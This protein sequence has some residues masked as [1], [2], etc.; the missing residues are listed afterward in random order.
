MNRK[1]RYWLLTLFLTITASVFAQQRNIIAVPDTKVSIGEAQLPVTIE[2]TDEIVGLQFD[3]TL[4][5]AVTAGSDAISTNRCDGHTIVIRKMEATRYRVMLYS[6]EM[7]PLIAQQGTV[8]YIPITTPQSYSQ[9]GEHPMSISNAT[10]TIASGE[11]VLTDAKA[12]KLIVTDL[13]DLTVKSIQPSGLTIV[14]NER[15]SLSWQVQN[16]GGASTGKGWSEQILLVNRLGTRTKLLATTYCEE[17]LTA[18]AVLTRQAEITV[19]KLLGIEGNAYLQVRIVPTSETGE[20]T[21]AQGNNTL[22]ATETF[23]VGK[24][25][26]VEISPSEISENSSQRIMVKVSRSGDWSGEQ[27]FSLSSSD[28]R[29]RLPQQVTIPASQSGAEVFT[30]I[31]DNTAIDSN[32]SVTISASGNG[33]DTATGQL[34]IIDNEFAN[35]TLTASKSTITEGETF[36]LTI[37]SSIT[38]KNNPLEV[39]LSCENAKRFSFPQ[40]VS[41]PV[42]KKTAKVEVTAID[43]DVPSQTLSTAFTASAPQYNKAEAIVLLQDNDLPVLTLELTPA[44]V[45]E[46]DG[47]LAVAAVLRRTTHTDAKITVRISD[48][49]NGA[50]YYGNQTLELAKGVEEVHFNLGPVDNSNVDGDRTY[51]ITAAVWLSS[52][53]CSAGGEAAG[54]VSAQLRVLDDDGPALSITSSKSTVKEGEKTTLT[55]ERNTSN[56][57]QALTV[58]LS[59]DYEDGLTYN[60]TVTIAAKKK[61]ATVEVTAK[62]NSQ[63]NDNH[64]VVFTAQANGFATGTCYIMVTDQTLPDARIS[65]F[66][67]NIQETEVGTEA[68]LTIV[69]N[70]E[71]AAELPA[72]VAVKVYRQGESKAVATLYT[73]EA[74]AIGGS[75]TLTRNIILPTEVGL[76]QFYAVVNESGE[77]NELSHTN[78]TS[79]MVDIRTVAPYSVTV[80]T[81]KTKYK[82]GET[83]VITGQLTGN[84][85]A[86]TAIDLYIINEGARQ[87]FPVTT[88]EQG[89][90]RYEYTPYSL[91]SGHFIVGACYPGE[92][93]TTQMAAFDIYG[94]RRVDNS[95]I[96][97]GVVCGETA[98]GNIGLYNPGN[99]SLTGV[100][101]EILS[102]PDNCVASVSIPSSIAGGKTVQLS[103][104]L[105]GTSPT[106]ENE[107]DAVKVKV[108]TSQGVTQE[109]TLYFYCRNATAK[110]MTNTQSIQ[111]TM[112]KDEGRDYQLQ[113]TNI[114]KGNSGKITLALPDWIKS[115]S[116]QTLPSLNQGDSITISLHFTPTDEMNLNV[117]VTGMFGINCEN[118]EGTYVNFNITPVSSV[119]GTLEVDVTDEY[120]YYTDE[121]PHVSN[122]QVVVRN[123]ATGALVAQGLTN[124]N[125]LYTISLPEG[126]YQLNVTADHHDSF[127]GNV[128]VD[129]G[130]T[131]RKTINLSVQ[132]ISVTWDVQ[133][134]EVEDEYEI[135]TTMKYETN[136]PTPVIEVD[137]PSRVAGEDLAPGES[138]IFYALLTNKG[139]ITALDVA[140]SLPEQT[141]EYLWEPLSQHTGLEIAPQTTVTIPIKLT[142]ADHVQGI[143]RASS[144]DDG[145]YIRTYY[146]WKW[147]CG[148]DF[149]WHWY[150]VPVQYK[151]C[152]SSPKPSDNNPPPIG[153]YPPIKPDHPTG[154]N[155]GPNGPNGPTIYTP[156]I[157]FPDIPTTIFDHCIPCVDHYG[158]KLVD[159]LLGFIPV[160]GCAK[161]G[162]DCSKEAIEGETGWRHNTNCALS[163][164]GCTAELCAEAT[165]STVV[166]APVAAGCEIVGWIANIG[167]C[168]VGFTEPCHPDEPPHSTRKAADVSNEPEYITLMRT[169]STIALSEVNA[170]LDV[171]LEFFGDS[172]WVNNTS[173]SE[174]YELLAELIHAESDILNADALRHLKPMG[175]TDA[176]FDRFIQR[177]NN[178]TLYQQNGQENDNRIHTEIIDAA[179]ER[180]GQAE[181]EAK[182]MGY[183]NTN[184][185]FQ[186][187]GTNCYQKVMEQNSSV[188]ATIS[189]QLS[190]QMA[191]TRQAFRGTLTV[192]NGNEETAMQDVKLTLTVTNSAT[193]EVATSHEFQINAESLEG[194]AGELTLDGGWTLAANATGTATVL[195]IPTKYAAPT[196]PVDYAFGG[197]LS[198]IDPFTGLEVTRDL[199]PVTLTVK[200]SPELDLAYFMQR[201]VYGDDPLTLDVVEAMKPAEFALLINNKG[202]GD[203]TN[204]RMV[205][206]QPEIIENEKGLAIVF[207][208]ISSQVNGGDAALSFGQSI[209]ND[210]GNIPAH[211]QLYAQWWLQ[212]S[213][214]GHFTDY[215]VSATHVSSYG[216]EDLSLL[217]EVTIHELIHGFNLTSGVSSGSATETLRAF[218]VNDIP[219]AN[220]LPDKLYFSNGDTI[221]VAIAASASVERLSPTSCRL[222]VIPSKAGWNYGSLLDPTYGLAELKSIVRQSDGKELSA[223]NFWQTD[224]T[225]RDGKDWLYENR[226]HFVDN[227]VS[228]ATETYLLTFEPLPEVLLA[229]EQFNGIPEEGTVAIEPVNSVQV[230]FTKPIAPATFTADDLAM[231][232][233]GVKQ[234]TKLIGI[235]TTDNQTFTLDLET[236]TATC[237]NGYYTLTVQT[238]GITD[239]EGFQ[240]RDGKQAAWVLF[241]GGLVQLLT[242]TYPENAGTIS[243]TTANPAKGSRRSPYYGNNSTAEYGSTVTLTAS[244]AVGYEL[245]N[246]TKNGEVIST[247]PQCSVLANDDL[248]IVANFQKTSHRVDVTIEGEGTVEEGATGIY[249]YGEQL[250]LT[251]VPAEGYAFKQWNANG[252]RHSTSPTIQW[253]VK[254]DATLSAIFTELPYA[255][256]SGLVRTSDTK[257]PIKDAVIT[258]TA[259]GKTYSTTSSSAGRYS[260]QVDDR[261]LVYAVS[262]QASGFM[263]GPDNDLTFES[264]TATIDFDLIR[265]ATVRMPNDGIC[266]FSSPVSLDFTT[267]ASD[268]I[269]YYA[270]NYTSE[271]VILRETEHSAAGE[272]LVLSGTSLKRVDIPE[273][274]YEAD[275]IVDNLLVGTAY[276]PYTVGNETVYILDNTTGTAK[277]QKASKGLVVPQYKA[278]LRMIVSGTPN[279]INII[280]GEPTLIDAIRTAAD[281]NGWYSLD[282][283]VIPQPKRGVNVTKRRK[284]TA[285]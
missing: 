64:T 99:L 213:L 22:Q 21:A 95:T 223:E 3:I 207:D 156:H 111:T 70:N 71:G 167:Q 65:S 27:V 212:S 236:L 83:V 101:A 128:L 204:V 26:F 262:C 129:P 136:V 8:F 67:A 44:T 181:E 57:S 231:N 86:S 209:A 98:T 179:W 132:A 51:N 32:S 100:T 145:C 201:D 34:V 31:T 30:T 133:E 48:D 258:L 5:T 267:V 78:N 220:D 215:D 260:I 284:I 11:N 1:T 171:Q 112:S 76:H 66:T 10:M 134:T 53:S 277:F 59:S 243:A 205:T 121:A 162:Y 17:T 192:F 56:V 193:G 182:Q 68:L 172:V 233:Q 206:Q 240:G 138:L 109:I 190:Q 35:L 75:Q 50:L 142:R 25:L 161:G 157:N 276:A 195:F 271:S 210:F 42:G 254:D 164:I 103:Y 104:S 221:G 123:A 184:E 244:P 183:E 237:P 264:N 60:H 72:G 275:A 225:L 85:T 266:T 176:E 94:L 251:A 169:A 198:Y 36:Q 174:Q 73:S 186:E 187:I 241:R 234:D 119:N 238:S 96:T 46:G 139:L 230:C 97:C 211:S 12:G 265:G 102:A 245:V 281:E 199:Y 55:V 24:R 189:L 23:S 69:V 124:A 117:P 2:N 232:V 250:T 49:A 274:E 140:L 226:L 175:I 105:K 114:G 155:E 79:Q 16:V 173:V 107:W 15:L 224:R 180:V 14:P 196:E 74:L 219:D 62:S 150:Q 203:A 43:D 130:T 202:N 116:G 197:T 54:S 88:D 9:G 268:V 214:L 170:Y 29:I 118:G 160:Y 285:K 41:I 126:Y 144:N 168:L 255:T 248:N 131:T 246:W 137:V 185:M 280:W 228:G 4:P 252:K 154:P 110:L 39:T 18:G 163:G 151:V 242:S 13:P 93:L 146:E 194:F 77:V 257:R 20:S 58:T 90:F 143:R 106:I 165:L 84:N 229:V 259:N 6:E 61:S 253:T 120:T 153:P 122:A 166:G 33:Y 227:L 89:A 218:L 149:K 282:G 239:F 278:Y 45:Q 92:G 63:S 19:P 87:V 222:T 135:V 127:S 148:S 115:L 247:E 270:E 47:P 147:K 80:A 40:T 261:A 283:K 178:T 152:P 200:P 37:S 208:I 273:A 28:T 82:Q 81:N 279:V 177:L 269:A 188:C 217:D 52:C 113:L 235:S 141:G 249:P 256:L 7:K 91:Q 158:K 263:D 159:C 272:G 108:S 38:V 216:N 191:M 125:G